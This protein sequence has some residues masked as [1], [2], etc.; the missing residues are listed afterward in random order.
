MFTCSMPNRQSKQSRRPERI[1]F[2][3]TKIAEN[4]SIRNWDRKNWNEW[5]GNLNR[6][7]W[8]RML[9]AVGWFLEQKNVNNMH[10]H[11]YSFVHRRLVEKLGNFDKFSKVYLFWD[12]LHG[13]GFY[14]VKSISSFS[15]FSFVSLWW[16][17]QI[18]IAKRDLLLLF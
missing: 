18:Q 2:S 3:K 7:A 8:T 14:V 9:I 13:I 6:I 5:I 4:V 11:L 1:L 12:L 15:L 17:N 10:K 16:L